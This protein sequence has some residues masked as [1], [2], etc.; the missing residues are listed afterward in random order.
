MINIYY[1]DKSISKIIDKKINNEFEIIVRHELLQ[2]IHNYKYNC[3]KEIIIEN[4]SKKYISY[5]MEEIKEIK[6]NIEK[7]VIKRLEQLKKG[8]F[9]NG[10]T[11]KI[12]KN[13]NKKNKIYYKTNIIP[14]RNN[15]ILFSNV[16][17]IPIRIDFYK[18]V[19][20]KIDVNTKD[21]GIN[22]L[23]LEI[24]IIIKVQEQIILPISSKKRNII[25]I[26][27]IEV[28]IIQGDIPNNINSLK[29]SDISK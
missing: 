8:D 20:S 22:N 3:N 13:K 19:D 9:S 1:I 12:I 15:S 2:T 14:F 5:N 6:R 17:T 10:Q 29:N 27:P 16:P 24:N 4:N 21:Y 25:I 18:F 23:L 28:A 11:I 26:E 7:K